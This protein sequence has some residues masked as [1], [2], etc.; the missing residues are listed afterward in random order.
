MASTARQ[1][2]LITRNNHAAVTSQLPWAA[3]QPPPLGLKIRNCV[4]IHGPFRMN[5]KSQMPHL[6]HNRDSQ[7]SR[8]QQRRGKTHKPSAYN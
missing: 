8:H 4:L 3:I 7:P 2:T 5:W 1:P 6:A